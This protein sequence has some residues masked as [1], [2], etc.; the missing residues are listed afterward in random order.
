MVVRSV[1][2]DAPLSE[3]E[4]TNAIKKL[5]N[6][7]ASGNN[8]ITA[9]LLKAGPTEL[10]DWL[11]ELLQQ[12]WSSGRVPQDW[13]DSVLV[14]VFKKNDRLICDNYCGI[15]LLS[16]PGKVLANILLERLKQSVEPLLLE[17]Q[18]SFRLGKGTI[19]QIW[20]VRQL[21]EKSIEHDCAVHICF[22]DLEKAFDSVPREILRLLLKERGIEEQVVQLIVDI[23]DGTHCV[24]KSSCEKSSKF[25]VTTGVR[26]GCA[27]SPVLFNLIMDKIVCEALNKA[28]VGGVE[29]EYRKEGSLYMNYRVKAQGTS[30]IKA[31]MYADNLALIGKTSSELQKLVDSLHESCCKWGMK[32]SIKKTKVLSIGYEQARILL[33]GS[34]LENVRVYLLGEYH[35]PR[36]W[37]HC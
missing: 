22:V 26:Q 17:A 16:V 24:V 31:A 10:V 33:D 2:S 27:M 7:R 6:N 11:S 3:E 9:E 32:I 34:V 4:I 18:C 19:D 1:G 5:K 36:W 14:P 29:I 25:E 35:E 20:L 15:S 12:V 13:K 28:K 37:M 21:I 8:G 23:H 30:I